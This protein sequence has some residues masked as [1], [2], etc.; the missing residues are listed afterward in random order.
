MSDTTILYVGVFCFSLIVIAL[1][2]AFRE[3]GK[4]TDESRARQAQAPRA[5]ASSSRA[6]IGSGRVT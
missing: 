4:M 2:V 6:V 5:A 3:I 1:I